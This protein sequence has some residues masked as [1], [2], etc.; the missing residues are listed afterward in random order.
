MT[1]GPGLAYC[2]RPHVGFSS[3]P[4]LDLSSILLALVVD[5]TSQAV[6]ALRLSVRVPPFE[7]SACGWMDPERLR[8]SVSPGVPKERRMFAVGLILIVVLASILVADHLRP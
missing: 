1:S 2:R 8:H 3:A 6:E 4:R 5:R 7:C